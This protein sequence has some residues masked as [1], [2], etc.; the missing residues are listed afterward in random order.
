MR[1][2]F[3]ELGKSGGDVRAGGF[4]AFDQG[5]NQIHIPHRFLSPSQT[6][7]DFRLFDLRHLPQAIDQ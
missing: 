4:F 2:D 3:G 5:A 1:G 7:G 6:A